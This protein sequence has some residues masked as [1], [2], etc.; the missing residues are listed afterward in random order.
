LRRAL[1]AALLAGALAA[2]AQNPPE[3]PPATPP[4]AEFAPAPGTETPAAP[5]GEP[6][7]AAPAAAP[8]EAP[9]PAPRAPPPKPP[10]PKPPTLTTPEPAHETEVAALRREVARLQSELDAERAAAVP[11]AE[12][13]GP[14]LPPVRAAWGWLIAVALLALAGGFLLGWRLLDR[15]IRRKYGGLRIY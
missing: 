8:Q 5:E 7:A 6:P 12:E 4:P 10:P 13:A 15:R 11:T 9:A 1:A 2:H 14:E 3:T